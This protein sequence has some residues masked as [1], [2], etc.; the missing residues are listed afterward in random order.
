MA[1]A[2]RVRPYSGPAVLMSPDLVAPNLFALFVTDYNQ[3]GRGEMHVGKEIAAESK[4]KRR[5]IRS[6]S[7]EVFEIAV[8]KGL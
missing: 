7:L 5:A 4:K 2:G 3:E 6:G 1:R 8:L